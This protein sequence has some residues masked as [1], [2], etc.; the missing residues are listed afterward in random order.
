[1]D[2]PRSGHVGLIMY[3]SRAP[4]LVAYKMNA[5][6]FRHIDPGLIDPLGKGFLIRGCVTR[7]GDPTRSVCVVVPYGDE[8]DVAFTRLLNL[9]VPRE[10]ADADPNTVNYKW[11]SAD[12]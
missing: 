5:P 2:I 4:G 1:M 9:V 11:V 12:P 7:S 8:D 10:K 6:T 3:V